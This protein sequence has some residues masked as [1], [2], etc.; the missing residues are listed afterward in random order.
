MVK[1]GDGRI[2]MWGRFIG[3]FQK[4][5]VSFSLYLPTL[6]YYYIH[7]VYIIYIILYYFQD[8]SVL[9][10]LFQDFPMFPCSHGNMF[11]SHVPMETTF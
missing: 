2:M 4:M 11:V 9:E 7:T 5:P 6:D 8:F 1:H 10:I 3:K